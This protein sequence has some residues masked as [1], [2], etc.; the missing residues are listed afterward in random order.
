M[1]N[2]PSPKVPL[3]YPSDKRT[4]VIGTN[5]DTG[6]PVELPIK[7]LKRHFVAL[8]SSGSG[9]TVICKVLM[10]EATR[11]D[12][13]TIIVD[14]QGDIASLGLFADPQSLPQKGIDPSFLEQYKE[15]ADVRIFTPA[16]SKGIPISIQPL[17]FPDPD[18]PKE[19]LIRGLDF[20][21]STLT[22]FLGYDDS[23]DQG[24]SAHSL[25]FHV[26]EHVFQTKTDISDFGMLADIVLS[27]PKPIEGI[28]ENIITSREKK[29]LAKRLRYLTVGTNSLMFNYG[30]PL[31]IDTFLTRDMTGKTPVNI[32]YLNTLNEQEDKLLFLGI[33]ARELYNWMLKHPSNQIQLIFYI[34]EIAPY[35]PPHPY[36][37]PPKTMLKMIFKQARKYGVG[38]VV[39]TQNPTDLD[40]KALAQVSTWALGRMMTRQDIDRV[41]HILR[42]ISPTNVD[43]IIDTL[44]KLQIG[45]FLFLSPDVFDS[46]IP[47]HARWLVTLHQTLDE[48]QIELAMNGDSKHFLEQVPQIEEEVQVQQEIQQPVQASQ[49]TI[50]RQL[51]VERT[52]DIEELTRLS[53]SNPDAILTILEKL[54]S[55][56][57]VQVMEIDGKKYFWLSKYALNPHDSTSQGIYLSK[58][59]VP[60]SLAQT[61]AKKFATGLRGIFGLGVKILRCQLSYLPV[62]IVD[63]TFQERRLIGKENI[64]E[65][66]FYIN[67]LNGQYLLI[68][69]STLSPA[70]LA[71]SSVT[72][73][74]VIHSEPIEE[75][76]EL[77]RRAFSDLLEPYYEPIITIE[78]SKRIV[79]S[80]WAAH[81]QRIVLGFFPIWEIELKRGNKLSTVTVDG[82]IGY[83]Y[84]VNPVP[85]NT[86]R[87]QNPTQ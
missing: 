77:V 21:A 28:L 65:R 23:S 18:L 35:L 85:K 49:E 10:E 82:I 79:H 84:P 34:D 48:D 12:I 30:L 47:L 69:N 6:A 71:Q 66:K 64:Q 1:S 31:N 70:F 74:E 5:Q 17:K 29:V 55:T 78:D 62:W 42:A 52:F 87:V 75:R 3:L 4:F 13:P 7:T 76:A 36:T 38:L 72:N 43:K 19:E 33:L 40:Y 32:I 16:S 11:H 51:D 59:K 63:T 61:N 14:P 54:V 45:D 37:P 20:M 46:V 50:L 2:D 9:K 56:K 27:P 73:P 8:G 44:P 57:Q 53:G 83:P 26:F 60:L 41:R 15:R 39:A 67:A 58:L 80:S 24:K 81:P 86:K 68:K 22:R 25:L